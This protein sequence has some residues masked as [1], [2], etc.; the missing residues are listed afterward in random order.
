MSK[1]YHA[2]AFST[3]TL[4]SGLTGFAVQAWLPEEG[5][6]TAGLAGA[7]VFLAGAL[8]H[9]ITVR[10]QG[11]HTLPQA[12]HLATDQTP[13]ADVE[14]GADPPDS[15]EAGL[16]QTIVEQLT[17]PTVASL[18]DDL[19][20]AA[21]EDQMLRLLREA[22]R[23]DRVDVFL[24]PIVSLPQRRHRF[25]EVYSRIRD[26]DGR[27]IGPD[28]YLALAEREGLIGAIDNLLLLRCVQIIRESQ[29]RDYNYGFFVNI[30]A[31]SLADLRFIRQFLQFMGKN[32]QLVPKVIFELHQDALSSG[33]S[34]QGQLLDGL[35]QLG[36]A[37]S[38]DN[39]TSFDIDFADLD[40]RNVRFVK[41]EASRLIDALSHGAVVPRLLANAADAKV[42]VII[43]KVETERQVQSLLKQGLDYGQG[44]LF[45]ELRSARLPG[46]I[47]GA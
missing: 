22:L 32:K 41:I 43:E 44:Y 46:A 38:M 23:R 10:R 21:E 33:G 27:Q 14:A 35:R 30:S 1:L 28:Q 5:S 3:Y 47:A 25:Y 8:L 9:E 34:M 24:Q 2:L 39:V 29:R 20:K 6:L 37:F 13:Q 11:G 18:A 16:L 31:N 40:R 15:G 42:D 45:G 19:R 17:E 12:V 26:E 7:W 4:A 36:F